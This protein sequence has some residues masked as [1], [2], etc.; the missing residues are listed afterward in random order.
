MDRRVFR[1]WIQEAK[2]NP[3]GVNQT[4]FLDN[5]GGHN[6]N[7]LLNECI[8]S[9]SIRLCYLPPNSTHL[10]QPADSFIIQ[11][12]KTLWKSEWDKEKFRLIEED[13]FS[14]KPN[15][16]GEWSGK[17]LNPGKS[18]Y[19]ALA[20]K[21]VGDLNAMRDSNG[22]SYARKAMIRCGL[23]KNLNGLWEES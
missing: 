3:T 9:T 22:I 18:F 7:E 21:C 13:V 12:I 20:A 10:C 23:S 5:A 8:K 16:S 11:K 6:G 17:M 1:E 2:C 14:N 4:I 19:L 15:L